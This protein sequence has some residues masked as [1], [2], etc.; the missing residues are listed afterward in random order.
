MKKKVLIV[1]P[2]VSGHIQNWLGDNDDYDYL[3][4]TCHQFNSLEEKINIK[5][6]YII[7]QL[8][9]F[10]LFPFVLFYHYLK[11]RP[12]LIHVHFLSSYGILSSF[13][14]GVKLLSL[15]GTDINGRMTN[16]KLFRFI[17]CMAMKNYEIINSPAQHMTDKISSWGVNRKKIRT[18]QY[19]IDTD[20]LDSIIISHN[21]KYRGNSTKF[22]VAS[23]RN[24]D[25][26]YQIEKLINS[27]K[28]L[29]K[30]QFTLKLFGKSN[31]PKIDN[32][33]RALCE[34]FDNIE[35]IGFVT[36]EQFY[37]NLLDCNAFVSLPTMDGT[38]LSVIECTYLGLAPVVTNLDFYSTDMI[39]DDSFKI[40]VNFNTEELKECLQSSVTLWN[41]NVVDENKKTIKYKYNLLNNRKLM[42][43]IYNELI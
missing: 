13:L 10:A 43:G 31:D 25:L 36:Q 40:K 23:I 39:L 1:G 27:W 20:R 21:Y 17:G 42:F 7:N 16:N 18:F 33:I 34:N 12:N 2:W 35:V 30:N 5:Q 24:W 22:V 4:V 3:I 9:S 19:G 38:P 29:D 32:K 8:I 28:H 6:V 41:R 14:P 26:L 15:W 37:N 11:Y